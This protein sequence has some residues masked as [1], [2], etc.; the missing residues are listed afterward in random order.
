[1]IKRILISRA[2]GVTDRPI[3]VAE[4]SIRVVTLGSREEF[5]TGNGSPTPTIDRTPRAVAVVT[6]GENDYVVQNPSWVFRN[7]LEHEGSII[8][9]HDETVDFVFTDDRHRVRIVERW[10]S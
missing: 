3:G 5:H 1:M 6:V 2:S 4:L 9:K 10:T 7:G 8:V